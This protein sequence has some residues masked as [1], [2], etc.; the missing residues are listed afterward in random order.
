[1]SR[2][3]PE[4]S[5]LPGISSGQPFLGQQPTHA[6][7]DEWCADDLYSQHGHND[8]E[9]AEYDVAAKTRECKVG[10]ENASFKID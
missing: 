6:G 9:L 2:H 10:K 3:L 7:N 8:A 1:M 4:M 5:P